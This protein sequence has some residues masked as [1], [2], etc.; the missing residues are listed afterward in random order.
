MC[1]GGAI[2]AG[3]RALG[4]DMDPLMV[5]DSIG[6]PVDPVLIDR[7]PVADREVPADLVGELIDM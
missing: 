2:G 3:L 5:V 7:Q 4:V 6:E 1:D